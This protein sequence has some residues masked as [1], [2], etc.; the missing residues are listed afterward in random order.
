VANLIPAPQTLFYSP[1]NN[2]SNITFTATTFS[3]T[4]QIGTN[5]LQLFLNG[6]DVSSQLVFNEN[7][8]GKTNF[9]V[10][11]TGGLAANTIFNGKI[12]VLNTNTPAR[13]TTN[14]WV[15]DTFP[16]SGTVTIEA[17]DYNYQGGL[18]QDNPPVSGYTPDGVL[19]NGGGFGYFDLIGS[20]DIDYHDTATSINAQERNQY[21][22]QDYVGTA[23]GVRVGDTQRQKDIAANVPDYGVWRMQAGEWLN[24]TRTFPNANYNVYLR[25]SSQS[26][27]DVRWDQIADATISNQVNTLVG[28]FLVPNTGSSTRYRYVPLSDAAGNPLVLGLSG[29]KSFRLTPTGGFDSERL[30]GGDD[31]GSLQPNY[32]LF[33]PTT[34]TPPSLPWLASAAPSSGATGVTLQPT[35]QLIILNRTTHVNTGSIVLRVNGVNVTGSSTISGTTSEGNGATITYTPAA[36]FQPN[37]T[38]TISLSF[39]DD[40]GTPNVQSNQWSFVT[41]NAPV[42]PAY[43][44]VGGGPGTNFSIQMAKAPN[45][46]DKA[47]F[48]DSTYRAERQLANQLIDPTTGQP[49]GN[50]CA[51]NGPFGFYTETNAI[52]YEEAGNATGYFGGDTTFPGLDPNSVGYNGGIPEFFAMAATIKL[53]LSAGHYRMGVASDDGFKVTVGTNTPPTDLLLGR[54]EGGRGPFETAFDFVVAAAGTYTFR[55]VYEQGQGGA[56]VEWYWIDVN[57]GNRTLVVPTPAPTVQLYSATTAKGPFTNDLTAVIDTANH[58]VTVPKSGSSHFYRLSAG[59]ALTITNTASSGGNIVLKYQ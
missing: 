32:I 8:S 2:G 20:P 57:T 13:G 49:Y 1:P 48:P 40:A 46:S 45:G 42:I 53:Y 47:S 25:T 36:F 44:A 51:N 38:N 35:I 6:V 27:Q 4:N 41:A 24:Y 58:I 54:Y 14:T 5:T 50:E 15:F 30:H 43:F 55:L 33:V 29:V 22:T 28:Q 11:Y 18:F 59:S 34:T 39:A 37:T 23:Q 31:N 56:S 12:I 19:T 16:T 7:G 52:N 21:R 9:F 17:E 3:T 10:R 26:R